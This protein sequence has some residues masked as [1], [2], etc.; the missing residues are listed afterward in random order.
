MS[1]STGRLKARVQVKPRQ[2]SNPQEERG[3]VSFDPLAYFDFDLLG[4][5]SAD[6]VLG[7]EVLLWIPMGSTSESDQFHS[8][9]H[10]LK[11]SCNRY[12]DW[13]MGRALASSTLDFEEGK[14]R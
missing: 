3:S 8:R 12:Y 13:V 4:P 9:L 14:C 7:F 6:V 2:E 11:T 5:T 1:R 10:R